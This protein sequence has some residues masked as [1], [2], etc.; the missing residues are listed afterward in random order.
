MILNLIKH[1]DLQMHPVGLLHHTTC[2]LSSP[3]Q[4]NPSPNSRRHHFY[5]LVTPFARRSA[6]QT[7]F[8]IISCADC[9]PST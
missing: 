4:S 5:P 3:T 6:Y 8:F 7:L 1:Y 2:Y 9:R